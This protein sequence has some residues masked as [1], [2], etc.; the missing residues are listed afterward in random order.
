M[1]TEWWIAI[2]VV[3]VIV[4]VI[5]AS[6]VFRSERSHQ[7]QDRRM[8]GLQQDGARTA[9]EQTS[10]REERRLEGMSAEDREW[11]QASLQRNRERGAPMPAP[12]AEVDR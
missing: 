11:E 10:Q 7:A 6:R 9:A 12:T 5:V 8:A 4:A 3:I 2:V 1:A